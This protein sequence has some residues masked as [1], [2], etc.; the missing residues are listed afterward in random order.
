MTGLTDSGTL[1]RLAY[2]GL[3]NL[4]VDADEVL[5]RSGLDPAE[6]YQA[7]LRTK[8]SGQPRFWK[9]AVELSG[10]PCIGLHLGEEMPVYKGQI[11][12]YLFLSSQTFGDGLRRVLNYQRLISD[13]LHGQITE[14]PSP[15]LTSY[16]SEHQHAT[17]H[18]AEA[19]VLGLIKGF[20]AVTDGT[21]KPE[22]IV[23]NHPPNTDIAEY[24][25]IF[26]C[27]V[28]FNAKS[29]QLFFPASMLSYRSLYAEPE[30]LNLHIQ[31]ADQHLAVLQQQDLMTEVRSQLGALLESGETTLGN[32]ANRLGVTPRHLRH[33]LD[34]AGTSFQRL[35][36]DYRHRLARRLLSQ[37][38]EGISEIV[39][40]TG[41]S[42]PST[43]YRAFRRWEGTTP[44]EYRQQHRV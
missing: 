19:M 8:F 39:Y 26:Q 9:A 33:Q 36:N 27:P 12:E 35:L 21:F 10:D 38:D 4:G 25:R 29:F 43:F 42:E 14:T 40:L 11:L 6:L 44:I 5:R 37:T 7:N 23:F 13:A 28:E 32:V 24:Q 30:L 3:V 18:L 1:V 15:C 20:Q 31:A 41:F 22:K 16:F 34:L 17:S 2:K